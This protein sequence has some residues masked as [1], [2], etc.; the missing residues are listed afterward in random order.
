MTKN[1]QN[2]LARIKALEDYNE[3]LKRELVASAARCERLMNFLNLKIDELLS[4][5]EKIK[6]LQMQINRF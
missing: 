4:A 1:E 3:R 2:L 6:K 5:E